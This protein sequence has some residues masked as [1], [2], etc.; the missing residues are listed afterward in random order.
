MTM[1]KITLLILILLIISMLIT[2]DT[3]SI[4]DNDV[5]Y[6]LFYISMTLLITVNKNILVM[7]Q[8]LMV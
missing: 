5:T 1:L 6:N 2:L 4:T 7:S 3:D 8:L